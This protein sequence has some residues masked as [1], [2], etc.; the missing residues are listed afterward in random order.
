MLIGLVGKPS[1]GKSTFMKAATMMDV[2]IA[3]YPF[4][5]I[6]PNTGVGYVR[7]KC[8]DREFGAQC[9]PRVGYC[10]NG[11]RYVPVS[12]IDV[13]G[14]VPG[15]HEGKGLGNRFLNDLNQADVLIHVLDVSGTTN[16]KG[17]AAAGYDPANDVRFL[18]N[19]IDLWY[20]SVLKKGWEKFSRQIQQ[21]KLEIEEAL[22]KQLA[23]FKV[24]YEMV[25]EAISKLKLDREKPTGWSEENLKNLAVELRRKTKPIIFACNKIDMPGA[26]K[27][28]ESLKKQFPELMMVP[29]S[30]DSEVA[31]RQAAEK[32]LIEYLPGEKDFTIKSGAN[33]HQK[34]VLEFIRK[35]VLEKFGSTGVQETL[36]KDVF[37]FLKYIA[38]FPGGVSKL[39]DS[40]GNVLPDCFLLPPGSTALDFA[41]KIHTDLGK[42]FLY[43]IDVRTKKRIGA[44]HL[45]KNRDVVEIVS[46]AK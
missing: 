36:D 13:A 21:S 8:A 44:E 7:V 11:T 27:N 24:S 30:A 9:N 15:A 34:A 22:S 1:S 29:C 35:N 39:S 33:E 32:G 25:K 26:D 16:E 19:E 18:E 17:E 31:L 23:A 5:T 2:A 43:A 6:K 46:A 14:L 45:M 12:L 37:E 4:T 3:S 42:H 41:N 10:K 20:L 38:I 40:K 28:Y